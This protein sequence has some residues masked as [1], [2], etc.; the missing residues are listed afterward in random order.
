MGEGK[1]GGSGKGLLL[2]HSVTL[3][4]FGSGSGVHIYGVCGLWEVNNSAGE[5]R[6]IQCGLL[7]P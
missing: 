7:T 5:N 2:T 4:L 6:K 1:L 3:L